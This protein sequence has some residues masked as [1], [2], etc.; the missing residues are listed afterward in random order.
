M[1]FFKAVDLFRSYVPVSIHQSFIEKG[2]NLE[3]MMKK[4]EI[5]LLTVNYLQLSHGRVIK[6]LKRITR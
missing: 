3:A 6:D 2:V 1:F 5:I 4:R